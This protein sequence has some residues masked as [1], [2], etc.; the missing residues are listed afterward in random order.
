MT[1]AT[2]E[3]RL[4]PVTAALGVLREY[5]GTPPEALRDAHAVIREARQ[6]AAEA[7]PAPA[8][9]YAREV[10]AAEDRPKALTAAAKRRAADRDRAEIASALFEAAVERAVSA[11]AE[12]ADEIADAILASDVLARAFAD[13]ERAVADVPASALAEPRSDDLDLLASVAVLRRAVVPFE[14]VLVSLTASG[15]VAEH[16][17]PGASGLLFADPAEA[18]PEAVRRALKGLRPGVPDVSVTRSRRPWH[19]TPRRSRR[20]ACP[21]RSSPGRP[22]S[23]SGRP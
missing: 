3:T 2:P 18:D 4:R 21:P 13:V 7:L 16:D 10:I 19:R 15:L 20:P 17:L 12:H 6:I 1:V 11:F 23:C 9:V 14:R 5:G 22:A 8:L